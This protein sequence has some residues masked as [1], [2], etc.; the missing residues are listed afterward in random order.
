VA[1]FDPTGTDF[2]IDEDAELKE[3]VLQ[4]MLE[5]MPSDLAYS[6]YGNEIQRV[7]ANEIERMSAAMWAIK[8]R[9]FV[10]LSDSEGLTWWEKL[11]G[12]PPNPSDLT[13]E[14][15]RN[16]VSVQMRGRIE[17]YG[18][19]FR[20]G[21]ELLGGPIRETIVNTATGEISVDFIGALTVSDVNRIEKYC[22][23]A[24][25]AHLQWVITSA[26]ASS[27]FIANMTPG[28]TKYV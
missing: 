28:D 19:D 7:L 24:G 20:N 23:T 17:F 26:G 2:F 22:L 10:H 11:L 4:R 8:I 18:K 12:L 21:L 1:I 16:V 27:G 15:R 9:S 5:S 13:V 3:G 25:P 14:Q 6:H